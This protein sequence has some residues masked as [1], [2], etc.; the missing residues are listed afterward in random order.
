MAADAFLLIF[1][2]LLTV[3]IVAQPLGSGLARLIEGETG[4]LLQKFEAGTARL[5]AFD[6]SEMRW[7][8]YAAAILT[9]NLIGIAVLFI[10]LMAQGILPLNPENMPGLSWHLALNTAISFVTNTNWQAYS[11]ENTLS[12][13][14]QMVGLTVQNFLS[15]ASGI[16]VAFALIRAFSRRCV[17]TLGNAWLDLFR[18]TLYVLLPLSLLLALFFVSQ[19]VLQNLLP[20]QHLTTLDGAAQTLP[21]GPVASQEAIKLLGTNGGGFFGANSAHPFENPTA[22]SNIV[23]M[24][25]ILLIPT[26]LCF[27]FGKAVSDKRQG[28]ALL[29]AMALIFIVAAAV[30]MKMEVNGNP[31]LLALGA[32]SAANLEGKETRFGVLTS[33]LYAVVTTATSTGA[34]NAMHDSFTALGGMVPMWLMQIGEVVF[35][36]VGSGLYGMLL[37]VL[38]TVFIAGLMIGRSPEYLGKKIEVYEMK[39]T[40][41]AILIPPAL[42]LLGTALALS[43]EAGCSGILNPGAHGFSEVLYAVSSAANNNGSAFAGLSVNTPFYNVLLAVAMLLG[44]FA[45]MIPV[46]AIAGSLVVKKRQPESKGSLSTR[47]PLFIGMLIAIILLI[48]ALTFIPALALGPVAEHLQFGRTH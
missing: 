6:T 28:H 22:L 9:L 48:G 12:Y 40:A 42:V 25:A 19:G 32:D 21:M 16:A 8:Q 24:L 30:V 33:S 34:V 35:G 44:R 36:G 10:L 47:S 11:G 39:M 37:F 15:A 18:I 4:A 27:A 5:F 14:S 2:L 26:A 20:Y 45:V 46:L 31:H 1:G 43:T 17:D 23:Q 3:L 29:W 38:L 7:Q 41:L 13:L